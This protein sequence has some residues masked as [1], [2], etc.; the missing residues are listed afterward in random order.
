MSLRRIFFH[1]ALILTSVAFV[2][3]FSY[4]TSPRYDFLGGDSAIFQVIG[5]FWAQ[6]FLPYVELFDHKGPLLFLLNAVGYAIAPRVGLMVLQ[7]ICLYVSLL[8]T[9]RAMSL[10][11]SSGWRVPFMVLAIIFY[12]AH[13]QEGNHL[14]EFTVAFTAAAMYLFLR[15]LKADEF[16]A[17]VGLIHGVGFGACLMIRAS[18]AAQICC[19]MFLLMVFTLR[20]GD[21]PTLRRNVLNFCAGAATIVLPFVIYF[22]AHGALSEMIYATFL[23]NAMYAVSVPHDLSAAATELFFAVHIMPLFVLLTMSAVKIFSGAR[24]RLTWSIFFVAAM[25]LLMMI[26]LRTFRHYCLLILPLMPFVFVVL[27]DVRRTLKRWF[28]REKNFLQK[29]IHVTIVLPATLLFVVYVGICNFVYVLP[30]KMYA[31][32]D[33]VAKI[34]RQDL[35][36][37]LFILPRDDESDFVG[38]E[39]FSSAEDLARL[40]PP[41]ERNSVVMWGVYCTTPHWVWRTGIKPRERIFFQNSTFMRIDPALRAEWFANIRRE[42]PRWILRGLFK[43][44]ENSSDPELERLLT[45]RYSLVGA[46]FIVPQVMELYRL[47]TK[48]EV[49]QSK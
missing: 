18:D 6:G 11:S 47:N 34:Y 4:S 41:D 42:E 40:I 31:T 2:Y 28:L 19:Q 10:Y 24:D 17:A 13:Y 30:L 33:G 45:E 8:F 38:V 21:L 29:F 32:I 20:E 1:G 25:I 14:E 49:E 43:E 9:W 22:V 44:H 12:A 7:V 26:N 27:R 37:E 46:T 16:P 48:H 3:V 5:K 36:G 15:G 35:R 23:F 39:K